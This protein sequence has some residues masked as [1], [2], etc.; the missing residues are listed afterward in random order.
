MNKNSQSD[1]IKKE[2]EHNLQHFQDE[3]SDCCGW[4]KTEPD[5]TELLLLIRQTDDK[6][7]QQ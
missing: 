7:L 3:P 5:A 4:K 2:Q 6:S 1:N